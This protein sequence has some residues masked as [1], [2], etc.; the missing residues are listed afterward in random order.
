MN[1][2]L[3]APHSDSLEE[4][5][6]Q[7]AGDIPLLCFTML[8]FLLMCEIVNAAYTASNFTSLTP[9]STAQTQ[10][11]YSPFFFFFLRLMWKLEEG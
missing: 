4:S 10:A 2:N 3:D 7:G 1:S 8:P 6:P 5:L 9:I 11:Q